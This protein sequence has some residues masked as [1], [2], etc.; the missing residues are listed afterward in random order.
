MN[1]TLYGSAS[2]KIDRAYID[3]V[4]ADSASWLCRPPAGLDD[5]SPANI[6]VHGITAD[7]VADFCRETLRPEQQ[8][9][10][11]YRARK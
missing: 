5:F 8:S 3:G 9:T 2:D 6:D 10:L 4:E 7:D 1:I 11:I